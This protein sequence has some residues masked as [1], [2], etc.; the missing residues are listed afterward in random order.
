MPTRTYVG[1]VV[2]LLLLLFAF[3]RCIII[4]AAWPL[5]GNYAALISCCHR[6]MIKLLTIS[7]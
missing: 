3:S 5:S 4:S 2:V 1:G 7:I 6:P